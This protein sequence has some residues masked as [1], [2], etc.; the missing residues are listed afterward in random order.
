ME[1]FGTDYPTADGSCIRDYIQVTDLVQAHIQALAYLRDKGESLTVNCG[2]GRG[3]SVLEVVDVVKRVSGTD[4]KVTLSG[5]RPGD[6]ASIVA[7]SDR[8]RAVLGWAPQYDNVEQIVTQALDWERRL[9]N[10]RS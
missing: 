9:H 2:Y 4:F 8:I 10:R 3:L 7:R 6:P 5:R 1:I